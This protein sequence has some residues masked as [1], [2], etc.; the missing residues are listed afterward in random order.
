MIL[1]SLPVLL[2]AA[3]FAPSASPKFVSGAGCC[4]LDDSTPG[5]C[6]RFSCVISGFSREA[7]ENCTLLDYYAEKWYLTADYYERVG[8]IRG[9]TCRLSVC[10]SLS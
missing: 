9:P 7:D 10:L 4:Q 3:F 6:E 1:D 5:R 2:R 8:L